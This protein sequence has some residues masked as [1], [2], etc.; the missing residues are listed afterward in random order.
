MNP[1]DNVERRD[2]DP[3]AHANLV[4]PDHDTQDLYDR[5]VNAVCYAIVNTPPVLVD[6]KFIAQA[7]NTLAGSAHR[8]GDSMREIVDLL[9]VLADQIED[10]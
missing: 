1:L 9:D 8:A 5:H 2:S 7:L 10:L 4:A 6:A 3:H